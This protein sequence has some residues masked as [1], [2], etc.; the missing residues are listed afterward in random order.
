MNSYVIFDFNEK[1]DAQYWRIVDDVVM[2]GK[3]SGTFTMNEEGHGVFQGRV[4]LDNNGGFSSVRHR[5]PKIWVKEFKKVVIKLRGD[6]KN[7]QF[8]IKANTRE[9]Y[10]YIAPFSTTGEWQEIEFPLENMYPSFRGRRLDQP[11]FS[12]DAIE[13]ITFLIGNKKEES[14]K[15]QLDKIV[16]E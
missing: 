7:Y 8:R 13:E 15:L 14:F 3:S 16:L 6:G 9:Y 10:S 1:S 5:F 11:N 2:G 12:K 4:S